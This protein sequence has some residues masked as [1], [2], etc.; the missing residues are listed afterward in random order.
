M[1]KTI[2]KENENKE[3]L[4]KETKQR[5]KNSKFRQ[6]GNFDFWVACYIFSIILKA[7]EKQQKR[8]HLGTPDWR[9]RNVGVQLQLSDCSKL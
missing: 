3:I 5:R 6:I 2:A 8:T 1:E 4:P 7:G 9:V